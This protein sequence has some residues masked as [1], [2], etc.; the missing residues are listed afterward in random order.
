MPSGVFK[1]KLLSRDL[2]AMTGVCAE[3]GPVKLRWRSP[4]RAGAKRTVA[5]ST[6]RK[7]ERKRSD[8]ANWIYLKKRPHGLDA[9]EAR[10][11]LEGRTCALCGSEENLVVDHDHLTG[12]IRD[13]LCRAHN[14]AM[15]LFDDDVALLRAAAD[16]VEGHHR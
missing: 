8:R 12:K 10:K 16:Y 15:G 9:Y 13:A 2:E 11:F 5:C 3:C 6:P 7:E 1:H 4:P 14:L